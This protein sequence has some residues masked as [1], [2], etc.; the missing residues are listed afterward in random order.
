MQHR[1]T[2]SIRTPKRAQA[3]WP[4]L[5]CQRRP[6]RVREQAHCSYRIRRSRPN[7]FQRQERRRST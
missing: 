2:I 5:T 7:G 6:N 3:H 1:S 4:R